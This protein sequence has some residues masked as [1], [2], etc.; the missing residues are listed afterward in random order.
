VLLMLMLVPAIRAC[1]KSWV[2]QA[3]QRLL[4]FSISDR[5]GKNSTLTNAV[6]RDGKSL[7]YSIAGDRSLNFG[8]RHY[9]L[10]ISL[11]WVLFWERTGD[12]ITYDACQSSRAL[13]SSSLKPC[14]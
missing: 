8:N 4:I 5:N 2:F 10:F 13:I 6:Y 11:Q 9:L 1:A 3:I 14:L 12:L 7:G